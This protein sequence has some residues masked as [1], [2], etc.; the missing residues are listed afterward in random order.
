MKIKRAITGRILIF[1]LIFL[2]SCQVK[3]D[4]LIEPTKDLSGVWRISKVIRN[5]VEITS[6][7]DTSNFRLELKNDKTYSLQNNKIPF[8][9]NANGMW[10][11]DDPLYPF[12]LSF[13]QADSTTTKIGNITTP[14]V[15]GERNFDI[16][17]SPGCFRNIYVY[18]FTKINN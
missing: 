16:T 5:S 4:V 18:S 2:A 17:F 13:L 3:K 6:W 11:A 9:V 14:I 7:V 8:I 12:Q 1:S 10:A 15:E